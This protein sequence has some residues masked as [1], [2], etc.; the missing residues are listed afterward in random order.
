MS[1]NTQKPVAAKSASKAIWVQKSLTKEHDSA[2]KNAHDTK[3]ILPLDQTS[4]S[5][6][7]AT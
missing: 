7:V 2:T 3:E 6:K 5:V 1:D 4:Q